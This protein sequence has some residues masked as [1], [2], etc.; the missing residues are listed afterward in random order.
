MAAANQ[1]TLWVPITGFTC[2]AIAVAM[3]IFMLGETQMYPI[4]SIIMMAAVA[5]FA[6]F[7]AINNVRARFV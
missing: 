7:Y 5:A 2:G 6:L 3:V 4:W 1:S